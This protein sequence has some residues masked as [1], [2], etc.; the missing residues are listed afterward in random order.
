[1]VVIISL[2]GTDWLANYF[3][4]NFLMIMALVSAP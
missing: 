3:L 1:M 4:M 2:G